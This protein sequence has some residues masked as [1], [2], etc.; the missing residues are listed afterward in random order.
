MSR[1]HKLTPLSFTCI[2]PQT[3]LPPNGRVCFHTGFITLP[4]QVITH[5]SWVAIHMTPS[6]P[7]SIMTCLHT[8]ILQFYKHILSITS[9]LTLPPMT[10][11]SY[12]WIEPHIIPPQPHFNFTSMPQDSLRTTHHSTLVSVD[13]TFCLHKVHTLLNPTQTRTAD[14]AFASEGSAPG[15]VRNLLPR[16]TV[17]IIPATAPRIIQSVVLLRKDRAYSDLKLKNDIC[18]Q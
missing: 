14:L 2:T 6:L 15:L 12:R 7:C 13:C 11:N 4:S 9:Y 8:T 16:N 10:T 17:P 3:P 1:I 18:K 5:I